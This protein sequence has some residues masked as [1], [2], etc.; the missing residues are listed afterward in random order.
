MALGSYGLE[1]FNFVQLHMGVE[2]SIVLFAESEKNAED[3]ATAGFLRFAE[4]EQVMS[5]YRPSSEVRV[6]QEKAVNQWVKVSPDL[7]KVLKQGKRISELSDGAFDMTAGP[8][9][10]LWRAARNSGKSPGYDELMEARALVGL[11][12][13]AL[14]EAESKVKILKEGVKIDLGGIAKGYACDEAMEAMARYGVTTAA[15]TAGGDLKVGD[16]PPGEKGWPVRVAGEDSVRMMKNVAVSTSGDTEQFVEVWGVRYSH[17]VDPRSGFGVSN[18]IQATV[19][20]KEG[21]L[22]DPL[23]TA[24]CV[25]GGELQPV[26]KKLGATVWL[27]TVSEP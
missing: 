10:E 27:K 11:K 14:D 9:V 17:I 1:R 23:A 15:V 19:V 3:A 25:R 21:L 13:V 26:A 12:F 22:T 24:F 8:Y 18:R 16:A 4:L 5:D 6:M 20:A 2:V 7:F